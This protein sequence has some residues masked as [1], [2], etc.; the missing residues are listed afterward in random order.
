MSGLPELLQRLEHELLQPGVR[1]DADRVAWLLTDEFREVGSSGRALSKAE[2]IA[3]L[4]VEAAAQWQ[5]SGFTAQALGPEAA[6]VTYTATK[7]L[8]DVNSTSSRSSVWVVREGRWQMLYHQ[9]TP[10][11]SWT[12]DPAGGTTPQRSLNRKMPREP[13]ARNI[14]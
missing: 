1:R 9:G 8:H 5:L 7:T 13:A 11:P 10:I 3:A 6:L 12:G 2:I 4:Q 14:P